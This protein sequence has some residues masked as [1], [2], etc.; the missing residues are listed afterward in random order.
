MSLT[1]R[2]TKL[3]P[4]ISLSA[5]SI[6]E[7]Q[8]R[9]GQSGMVLKSQSLTF[10]GVANIIEDAVV[11]LPQLH[12]RG[13]LLNFC[14]TTH[15]EEFTGP[16][17]SRE[18]LKIQIAQPPRIGEQET[19]SQLSLI[20]EASFSTIKGEQSSAIFT[21]SPDEQLDNVE[22]AMDEPTPVNEAEMERQSGIFL[23]GL[24]EGRCLSQMALSDVV[25][26]L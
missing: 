19:R 20:E 6:N 14:H 15:V 25:K 8:C 18:A 3:R 26:R 23:L 16:G 17:W 4:S 2:S 12:F 7:Q 1:V 11:L 24:K 10:E 13:R 22:E 5:C 21:S 9:I